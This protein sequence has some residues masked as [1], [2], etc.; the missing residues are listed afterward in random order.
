MKNLLIGNTS[1]LSQY[2]PKNYI[3]ISSRD[4]NF[5]DLQRDKYKSVYLS[6]A[7]QRTFIED[8]ENMFIDTNFKYTLDVINIF[9]TISK[10]IVVYSTCELWNNINGE[11]KI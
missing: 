8:N 5:K 6:F 10:R 3:K 7:D 4:I 9:K 1:Q 2:F 11:I